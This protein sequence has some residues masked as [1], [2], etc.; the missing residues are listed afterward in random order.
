MSDS[1]GDYGQ[2][3]KDA[4]EVFFKFP[5]TCASQITLPMQEIADLDGVRGTAPAEYFCGDYKCYPLIGVAKHGSCTFVF[6]LDTAKKNLRR[7][8]VL[9]G[10][11]GGKL[12]S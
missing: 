12:L 7:L 3:L 6:S 1:D 5:F 4:L 10:S 9:G 2:D 8:D 11:D